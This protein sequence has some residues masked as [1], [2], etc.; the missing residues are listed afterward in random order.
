MSCV[1]EEDLQQQLR[2]RQAEL[3]VHHHNALYLVVALLM[4]FLTLM[5]A[6]Q[7]LY[8]HQVFKL[9]RDNAGFINANVQAITELLDLLVVGYLGHLSD[10]LGRIP[11]LVYGFLLAGTMALL[12]PFDREIAAFLGVNALLVF[13]LV[14][15]LV[16]LGGTAAWPQVAALTGDYTQ[17]GER[18][19]MLA[20]V[21]FMMA[22]GVTLVYAVLM[23]L[24][25]QIGVVMTMELAALIAFAGAWLSRG[26]L[27]EVA[28]PRGH[29]KFPLR[30]VWDLFRRE[31]RLR[32]SFLSAFTSRNDMVIIGLFMMTWFIYFTDL[33][34]GMSHT[35]AASR[36]GLV[37]G[38]LG[39]V[40]LVSIPIWGRVIERLGQVFSIAIGL[41]LSGFGF[42]SLGLIIDPFSWWIAVPVFLI[43]VGQAGCLL[44]PQLLALDIA[45][46]KIRGSVLGAFNT[47]GCIGVIFFLQVG[48]ILFDWIGPTA[49]FVFTGIANLLLVGYALLILKTPEAS[50][51]ESIV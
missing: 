14:R 13:Y 31:Q 3:R 7:P 23:Q 11:L 8:L 32:L 16:S 12:A 50:R 30:L 46:V 10:R 21:G 40:V 47:V 20:N 25:Q 24:P 36:A 42:V 29:H 27:V 15:I 19:R 6:L 2:S 17:P 48:G 51:T 28:A 39:V 44:V 26:T 33:V 45:P 49:P 9:A 22:F 5:V 18:H 34:D 37:I 4:I 43:G 35:Q 38:L 41:F 1:G